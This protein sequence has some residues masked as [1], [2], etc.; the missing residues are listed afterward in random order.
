MSLTN[1]PKRDRRSIRI[2][3][4]DYS[5]AGAYFVTICTYHRQPLFGVIVT[6]PMPGM[7]LSHAGRIVEDHWRQITAHR[8]SVAL[9]TFVV[10]PNHIHGIVWLLPQT[11][12]GQQAQVTEDRSAPV[13]G[14]LASVIRSFKAGVTSAVHRLGLQYGPIWQRNYY[15]SVIRNERELTAV[16]RYIIEN[17]LKWTFDPDNPINRRHS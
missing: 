14:S 11:T 1:D 6:D 4:F 12:D 15:E 9:D 17:P 3:G 7:S 5:G 10:M 13:P 2:P 16:R 8:P